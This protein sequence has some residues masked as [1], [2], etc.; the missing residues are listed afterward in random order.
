ML[1]TK[2]QRRRPPSK[3]LHFSD[4]SRLRIFLKLPLYRHETPPWQWCPIGDANLR[5]R[6]EVSKTSVHAYPPRRLNTDS[7][8]A[9]NTNTSGLKVPDGEI[10]PSGTPPLRKGREYYLELLVSLPQHSGC[11]GNAERSQPPPRAW[12]SVTAS[13][14]RRPRIFTAVSSSE[15]AAL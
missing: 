14:M 2:L 10:T 15:R 5:G 12:T 3:V 13:T 4:L 6:K 1:G 9:T 11:S 8:R 7:P